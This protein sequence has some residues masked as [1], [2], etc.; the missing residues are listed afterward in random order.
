MKL[1][2]IKNGNNCEWT[3]KGYE[4]PKFNIDQMRAETYQQPTWVHFGAGNIFRAFPAAILQQVL[5]SGSYNKGVIVAEG[6]DYEIIDKAYKDYDNLSLLVCLT[7]DGSIKKKVIASVAESLKADPLFG[8]DW[9]RLKEI[10][11]NPSLQMVSFT[12]TE[13][14][15]AAPYEDLKRGL[16][17]TSVMGKVTVL[18]YY[19]YLTGEI[20]LTMQSMDNCSCNGDKLKA[21]VVAYAQSWVK[22]KL[23]P[24][25]F[26]FYVRDSGKIAYPWSMIDRIT[27]RPD[28]IVQ[29]MLK[30]DGFEDNNIIITEKNT[31]TAPFVNA[32]ETQY[33]VM[34][35]IYTNK[36]PPLELG[37]ALYT[38]RETVEKVE[39]MK[40]GTCL[41]PLHTAMA[42]FGCLLGCKR[43]SEEMKDQDIR[44]FVTKLGYLE[45][46]PVVSDPKIIK[47][48]EFI[49]FV[50]NRRLP[51][52]FLPDTP[53]RI[54]TD[55]SQKLS[56]RFGG[57]I[58]EYQK[59]GLK[60]EKLVLIPL[61]LA[62]YSR[63]LSGIDDNGETFLPSPDPMLK[64]LRTIIA[65][66]AVTEKKQDF[67]CLKDLY[68]R[69][70]VFGVDLYAAG[71]GKKIESM[72]QELFSGRGAVRRTLHKY[73]SV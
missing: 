70:D 62:G 13:K 21:A 24:E 67:S 29:S 60:M 9:K 2:D 16:N 58:R 1:K 53:Q 48:Q 55:T 38:D 36:R 4:L 42:I 6:F 54:A 25:E 14:G 52:P 10:F 63:Y 65:P 26:L 44:E 19:R 47:P 50:L 5:N 45:A 40:V 22:E 73:V 68:S 66:L 20:P 30:A 31:Y 27:P 37:G 34:E 32:E 72:A 28:G 71:L 7:S 56:I 12:V 8:S 11:K 23:V 61:V 33:L 35:D 46:L 18:L 3:A 69:E 64:E 51:N 39:K 43:I 49:D 57:T 15:Y 41:N 17:P 59:Q